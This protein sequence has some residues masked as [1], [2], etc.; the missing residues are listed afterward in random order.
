MILGS[1]NT[2]TYL[3][4]DNKFL[5]LFKFI[6]KCQNR[7]ICEQFESGCRCFD[8]RIRLDKNYKWVFA[9]GIFKSSEYSPVDIFNKLN[10][11]AVMTQE[12]IYIRLLLET[13]K[14]DW[15]QEIE[16][17]KFCKEL[18]AKYSDFLVFFEGRRKYDW[19]QLYDFKNNPD[20]IQYV[21]SMC[22]WYGKIW[23]KLYWW[24]NNNKN[25]KKAKNQ[26]DNTIC[27]FDFV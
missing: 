24:I 3:A 16:F 8:I 26:K 17:I 23:P 18:S 12:K 21:G 19:V 2:M 6:Y 14:Y 1:H 20:L 13:S 10:A 22:S 15:K 9:H 7:S 25:I 5:K 4:P 11:L 27:L